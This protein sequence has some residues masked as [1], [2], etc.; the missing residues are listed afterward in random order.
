MNTVFY[1]FLI[2]L[3]RVHP[4]NPCTILLPVCVNTHSAVSLTQ[5]F[6]LEREEMAYQDGAI[7]VWFG[8]N[9]RNDAQYLEKWRDA[10]LTYFPE[11]ETDENWNADRYEV[12]LGIDQSGALFQR[13]ARLTLSNL[14]YPPEVMSTVSDFG[15]V[16]RAIQ[17]GDRVVQR[18]RVFQYRGIPILETLTMNEIT[19]VIQEPRRAGFTYTTTT[20]HAEIG[21]W[22]PSVEWRENGEIVLVI[23]VVSRSR[24]GA[25][26]YIRQHSRRLQLRAHKL[27]IQ[28]FRA[29]LYGVPYAPPQPATSTA[30]SLLPVAML[31]VATLLFFYTILGFSRNDS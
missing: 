13:A 1:I 23:S 14:F 31:L 19:Q 15:L 5:Y 4:W 6:R 17:S 29:M 28:N 30:V 7:L 25:S 22:S 20:A 2:H 16:G 9:Q 12:V 8:R 18:I 21:E 27:S 10:P 24:P 26:S 11:Q 3:I